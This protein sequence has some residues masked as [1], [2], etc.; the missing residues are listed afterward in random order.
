MSALT[1][2]FGKKLKE[3]N[4][5]LDIALPIGSQLRREGMAISQR[6]KELH[7]ELVQ[8]DIADRRTGRED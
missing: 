5:F 8:Q 6:L 1:K 2:R 4:E 3:L 7:R